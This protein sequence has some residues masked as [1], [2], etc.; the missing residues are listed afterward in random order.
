MDRRHHF[1]DGTFDYRTRYFRLIFKTV[2]KLKPRIV[3]IFSRARI[4]LHNH[5]RI[6]ELSGPRDMPR[7]C[8]VNLRALY[9]RCPHQNNLLEGATM[10]DSLIDC[11]FHQFS[12]GRSHGRKF[13][14]AERLS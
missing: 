4:A 6:Y 1:D 5:A 14:T 11:P 10:W 9:G 7:L 2:Y 12:L 13:P 8:K 3:A